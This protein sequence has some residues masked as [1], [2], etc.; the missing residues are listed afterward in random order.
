MRA[1][2]LFRFVRFCDTMR[3][4]RTALMERAEVW[5][6]G[7]WLSAGV[8]ANFAGRACYAGGRGGSRLKETAMRNGVVIMLALVSVTVAQ[9]SVTVD[10]VDVG[11][12]GNPNDTEA[13]PAGAVA[14]DYAMGDVRSHRP[15]SIRSFSTP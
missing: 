11:H 14:Y 9:A 5:L 4:L 2:F 10:F 15:G 13:I 1:S 8:W 12:A 7:L 6:I 3:V